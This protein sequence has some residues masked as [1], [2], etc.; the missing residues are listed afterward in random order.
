M[1]IFSI[2]APLPPPLTPFC[3]QLA[4]L[5]WQ[6]NIYT[7]PRF[8]KAIY[9]QFMEFEVLPNASEFFYYISILPR[10]RHHSWGSFNF[11]PAAC[12]PPP[13]RLLTHILV[14]SFAIRAACMHIARETCFVHYF[15]MHQCSV[16]QLYGFENCTRVL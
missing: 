1:N 14:P 8:C 16:P 3:R 13:P 10:N 6:S 2:L 15:Q 9:Q 4:R 5:L 11:S 7:F 12:P